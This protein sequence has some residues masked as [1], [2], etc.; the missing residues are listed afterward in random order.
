MILQLKR[1]SPLFGSELLPAIAARVP[2]LV[3]SHSGMATLLG[4][5]YQDE[6]VVKESTLQPDVKMWRDGILQKLL[7][8]KESQQRADR[9]REQ[10]PLDTSIAQMHLN[11]IGTVVGKCITQQTFKK[12]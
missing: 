1:G 8:P 2:I 4:M 5:I 9:L 7:R 6:S 12:M 11:F 10:H 3:S